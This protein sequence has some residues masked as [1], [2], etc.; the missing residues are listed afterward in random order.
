MVTAAL[1]I[2]GHVVVQSPSSGHSLWP[3]GLQHASSPCPSPSP[4]VCPSSRSLHCW[5][6]PGISSSDALFSFSSQSFPS[7]GT[8]PT[9]QLFTLDGQNT[10]TSASTLVFPVNIQGWSPLRLTDLIS[11]LSTELSGV[12]SS[13]T[14]WRH[15][16]F[17]ILPSLQSS[18][19]NCMWP[20]GG[21]EPW[22][23]R[24]L[25]AE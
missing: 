4:R 25:S 11:L 15:Q 1:C 12:F 16:F 24:P 6:C 9:S 2:I 22:L 3:N 14:V 17:D 21:P 18:S 23:Y 10:G 13:T 20:L 5:C 7:S 19:H 8:F